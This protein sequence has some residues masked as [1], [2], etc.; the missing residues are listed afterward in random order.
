MAKKPF[1]SV[2][3]DDL[4]LENKEAEEAA[5]A[6]TALCWTLSRKL[7]ANDQEARLS[8]KLVNHLCPDGRRRRQ[9]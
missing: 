4:G 7:W 9:L 1:R 3:N 5:K 6:T 2:L 8:K